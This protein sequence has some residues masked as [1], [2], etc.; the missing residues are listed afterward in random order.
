MLNK[1]KAD[2]EDLWLLAKYKEKVMYHSNLDIEKG[3]NELIV[4]DEADEYIYGNTGAFLKLISESQ[5]IC[6]TAT[7]GG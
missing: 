6:L 7:R 1:D 3:N 2:F 4:F 5:C